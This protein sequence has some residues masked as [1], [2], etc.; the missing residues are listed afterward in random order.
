MAYTA[1]YRKFRPQTFDSVIGQ[2][3]IVKTLKNQMKTQRVS[4]AYLFCGTRGTG[5]TSTAKIFARAI[6]C[7][8]PTADGEPCNECAVCQDILAGRSVNVIE[9]DAASNNGV[10]NIREIR[11]EV[12]YPPTQ[13]KFKVYIVDEVHMLSTAAFNALLKTLEEP[14][15]HVIFILATTDPQKVPATI[16]SRV[17]RFDFRRITTDTIADTMMGY[18]QEEGHRAT[19]EAVRYVA[20][21]GDGSMRDSLSILDQCLAFFSG[22]EVTLEKVLDIMGAVDQTIFFEM[23]EALA[24][25]DA[26]KAMTLVEEMMLSGRDVKQFVTELLQHLR[27]LL[28]AATIP[29]AGM[30]LDLAKENADRLQAAAKVLSPEEIIY[31]IGKFSDLQSE[32]K[33]APNERIL[34]EVELMKL[35]APWTEKDVTTL[36]A[37]LGELERKVAEGVQ[38]VAVPAEGTTAVPKEKPKPKRKP[39]ATPEDVKKVQDQWGLICGEVGDMML[40]ATLRTTGIQFKE[41]NALYLV[42][43]NVVAANLLERNLEQI[44]GLLEKAADKSFD[45][46]VIVKKEYD[47][48]YERTYGKAEDFSTEE[49]DAEF[50]SLLGAYFPEAD[51]E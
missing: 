24:R 34:L 31:L 7:T 2:D 12:K 38:V 49:E 15:A 25:K 32:M 40:K 1:L 6:N 8:N 43:D 4:H 14:P 22:E 50:A 51:V 19:P 23:T 48:W 21:L 20:Q 3:H 11:E 18:L 33:W 13:G 27:N 17:Q 5:K 28:L 44:N 39:P 26:K 47:D 30:V 42:C 29:D 46:H 36:A 35:C 41:D 9:I 37:R 16:L 45:V 10:D